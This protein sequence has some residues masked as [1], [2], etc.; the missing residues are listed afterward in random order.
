MSNVDI[1]RLFQIR[2]V[3]TNF[4]IYVL[5]DIQIG[6]DKSYFV[7]KKKNL[8]FWQQVLWN[9]YHQNDDFWIENICVMF[10]GR[11]FQQRVDIS[12]GM[13]LCYSFRQLNDVLVRG[14]LHIGYSQEKKTQLDPFISR[15]VIFFAFH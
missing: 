8:W 15:S 6:R 3:R 13:Q 2:V 9:W 1:W 14:R 12:V 7:K 11:E 10:G 5:W 4:D